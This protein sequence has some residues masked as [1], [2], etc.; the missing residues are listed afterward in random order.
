VALTHYHREYA[1]RLLNSVPARHAAVRPSRNRV[2]DEAVRQAL[3]VLWKAADRIGGK[4]LKALIPLL[5]E[6]MEHH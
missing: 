1:I 3:E 5:I 2:Y 4:R 6:A